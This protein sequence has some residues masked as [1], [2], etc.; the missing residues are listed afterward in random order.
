MIVIDLFVS[1]APACQRCLYNNSVY[2][3]GS[4]WVN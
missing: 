2:G 4:A 3:D 1:D